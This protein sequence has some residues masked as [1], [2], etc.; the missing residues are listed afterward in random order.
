MA[1]STPQSRPTDPVPA[2]GDL[3]EAIAIRALFL[4]IRTRVISGLLLALPIVL[5]FWIIYWLYTTLTHAIL[6]PLTA[7]LGPLFHSP[8][9]QTLWWKRFVNPLIA[10]ILVLGFLY[11]LGLFARSWVSRTID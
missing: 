6:D 5:T 1:T 11:C 4:A 7:L 9:A 2:S 8:W 3:N 10:I